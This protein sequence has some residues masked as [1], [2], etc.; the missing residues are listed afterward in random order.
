MKE[1]VE[2]TRLARACRSMLRGD[3]AQVKERAQDAL[4]AQPKHGRVA[5]GRAILG[6][7]SVEDAF[8]RSAHLFWCATDSIVVEP[9]TPLW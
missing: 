9:P 8:Y 4:D 1:G 2:M 6:W 3:E 7:L 5:S